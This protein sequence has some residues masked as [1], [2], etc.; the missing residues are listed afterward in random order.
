MREE[1]VTRFMLAFVR[2]CGV[3]IAISVFFAAAHGP[4]GSSHQGDTSRLMAAT[5][6]ASIDAIVH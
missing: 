5:S 3:A 4:A 6:H 1:T 2:N